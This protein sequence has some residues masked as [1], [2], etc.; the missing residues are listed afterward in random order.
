MMMKAV[1]LVDHNKAEMREIPIPVCKKGEILIQTK[2]AT[3][4]TSDILDMRHNLFNLSFPIVMGHEGAGVVAA[5]GEGVDDIKV[6]DEVAVHPVMPCYKC[7]SCK[8]MIPHL[9]DDMQHLA[10]NLPGCFAEYFVT[11]P[12]CVR[13]KPAGLSFALASLMEPVCVCLEAINRADVLPR[14]RVLIAG[15]GP[16]GIM[17]SKLC[18]SKNPEMIIQTGLHDSRLKI[19]ADEGRVKTLNIGSVYEPVKEIMDLTDKE[20]IDKAILCVSS[21]EAFD[22]CF[23]VLRS[24]GILVVFSA[25]NEK[26]PVDLMRLHLKELTIAGSNNDE[27][28]MDEA[29]RLLQDPGLNMKSI[30]T[31]ELPFESWADAFRLAEFDKEKCL[32]VSMIF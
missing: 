19:A 6:G 23:D 17:M 22:L 21:P 12:D 10:F 15:D 3:V 4:C 16:F 28:F 31:H 20:G 13:I 24:R 5:V 2:A 14:D 11:R 7:P 27:D 25:L 18:S 1:M 8:K 32:K 29:I 9:C 30:V 26:V